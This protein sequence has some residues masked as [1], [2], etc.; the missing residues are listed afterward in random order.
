MQSPNTAQP[1]KL[2]GSLDYSELPS[3]SQMFQA[4]V[5]V[6]ASVNDGGISN[7]KRSD[8]GNGVEI[9]STFPISDPQ[10]F[11]AGSFEARIVSFALCA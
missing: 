11:L 10:T 7:R 1:K 6:T 9:F 2:S 8:M 5:G 3:S 4:P